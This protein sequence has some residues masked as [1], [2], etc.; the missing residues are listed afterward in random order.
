MT[1]PMRPDVTSVTRRA[2][3]KVSNVQ[4]T[5]IST[6]RYGARSGVRFERQFRSLCPAD[7]SLSPPERLGSAGSLVGTRYGRRHGL[8]H[9]HVQQVQSGAGRERRGEESTG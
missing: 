8:R 1:T 2:L 4:W 9:G 5:F 7:P 6:M 3:A